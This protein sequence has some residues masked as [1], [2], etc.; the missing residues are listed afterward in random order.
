MSIV[1][2]LTHMARWALGSG[3][4]GT[5]RGVLGNL[6]M[7]SVTAGSEFS[8]AIVTTGSFCWGDNLDGQLG[9]G[10]GLDRGSLSR[11]LHQVANSPRS[12]P[13]RISVA[14]SQKWRRL[15]L[16]RQLRRPVRQWDDEC[17]CFADGGQRLHIVF[18]LAAG[19]FHACG[20]TSGGVA[21]CW[22]ANADGELGTG[23]TVDAS[24]PRWSIRGVASRRLSPATISHVRSTRRGLLTVGE[25][26]PTAHWGTGVPGAR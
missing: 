7:Q 24:F 5:P 6:A 25:P 2:G 12:Q 19:A 9:D 26:I 18:G 20:L 13:G 11:L 15:L 17:A 4:R 14:V 3:R 23:N 1:G 22:G 8:C 21:Y 16:G 10:T